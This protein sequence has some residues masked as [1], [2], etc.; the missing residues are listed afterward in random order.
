M[1]LVSRNNQYK[2]SKSI[3]RGLFDV[4]VFL[5]IVLLLALIM[6]AFIFERVTVLNYSMENTLSPCDSVLVEKISKYYRKPKR[7]DIIVF[8]QNGTGEE[9]IKRVIGLPGETIQI[10]N[11]YI[12]VNGK[13]IDD[14]PGLVAPENPGRAARA[15]SLM[16]GEYF[17]LGDNREDSIDSRYDEIGNVTDTRII[18]RAMM[19]IYPI[20]KMKFFN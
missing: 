10:G 19:R 1:K 2:K 17:V 5:L 14:Y 4:G 12:Y 18:G 3:L 15:I 7:F 9:L 11:G 8:K 13:P 6:K 16:P 20:S